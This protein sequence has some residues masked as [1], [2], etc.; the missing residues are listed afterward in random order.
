MAGE[1]LGKVFLGGIRVDRKV[2]DGIYAIANR[3]NEITSLTV[4]RALRHYVND[5]KRWRRNSGK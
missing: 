5:D 1:T 2:L 3:R 4:E